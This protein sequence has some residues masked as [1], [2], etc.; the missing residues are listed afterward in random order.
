M[1]PQRT[2]ER[3]TLRT[4]AEET[5]FAVTTVS[6][7]LKDDPRI[8]AKTRKAVA[9]AAEKLAYVPDRAAQRLRTGRT[10]VIS[11]LLNL[12]HEFIG[13]ADELLGGIIESLH[14]TDFA[15]SINPDLNNPDRL[16]TIRNV[17]RNKLADGVILTRTEPFDDRVRL[18]H[19]AGLPFVTHGRT[20][21]TTPHAWVDF[22]N[23]MFAR[24][25]VQ[26][27][28]EKGCKRVLM[29]MPDTR[30]TFAQHL[31]YGFQSAARDAGLA[32]EI[33]EAVNLESPSEQIAEFLKTRYSTDNPPDGHVCVG[34]VVAM[35]T[36]SALYDSGLTPGLDATVLAKQASPTFKHV[37]P[38]IE[39]VSE[40]LRE[41]G[42]HLGALLLRQINGESPEGLHALMQPDPVFRISG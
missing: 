28:A 42:R 24:N 25:A 30:Y 23:E 35:A 19:E 15:I 36:L 20:E 22:D 32:F 40:D 3:P 10:K 41:T 34:E 9:E 8:A 21:F 18:L 11:V 31:R 33:P 26:R 37:R 17:H 13:F 29:V 27:L 14:G 16:D 2:R 5:G 4:I 38:R 6:R 39:T 7:A 1:S 12:E